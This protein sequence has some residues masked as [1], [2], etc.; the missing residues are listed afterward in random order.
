MIQYQMDIWI[1]LFQPI[2]NRLREED[3]TMLSARAAK[4]HHQIREMPFLV[5][6]NTL[7]DNAFH[8][9]KEVMDGWFCHEVVDDFPVAA[10]LS[11]EL[12]LSTRV[13][14]GTAVE[15]VAAAVSA[16]VVGVAFFE[17]KTVDGYGKFRV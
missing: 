15:D 4:G 14:Q 5:V 13:G 3:G 7:T 6:L 9:V 11:L 16:E 17:R 1:S 8:M 12:R 10:G 2:V